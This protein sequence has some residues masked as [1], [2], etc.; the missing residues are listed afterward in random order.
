MSNC[1]PGRLLSTSEV[2]SFVLAYLVVKVKIGDARGL[3]GRR[4]NGQRRQK[5]ER[6]KLELRERAH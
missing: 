4:Q 2:E 5:R 1:A 6:E 3:A